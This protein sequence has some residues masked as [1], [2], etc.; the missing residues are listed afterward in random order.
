MRVR[1]ASHLQPF[2]N[3]ARMFTKGLISPRVM[4]PWSTSRNHRASFTNKLVAI[5][6]LAYHPHMWYVVYTGGYSDSLSQWMVLNCS[7][8][9]VTWDP[10]LTVTLPLARVEVHKV[11]HQ[12]KFPLW[13]GSL[14]IIREGGKLSPLQVLVIKLARCNIL[15]A[16]EWVPFSKST[17]NEAK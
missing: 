8:S 9:Y 16:R 2:P 15:H 12:I 7:A 13:S 4:L 11:D 5:G 14:I 6:Y 3:L 17:S 1:V 10:T